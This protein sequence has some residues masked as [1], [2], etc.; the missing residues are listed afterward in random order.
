MKKK[1]MATL[2][3][4][5]CCC[6]AATKVCRTSL[7]D[8]KTPADTTTVEKHYKEVRRPTPNLGKGRNEVIG[9]VLHHTAEPQPVSRSVNKL[10]DP[11]SGV[12]SHVVIDTDGTRYVLAPP[13]AVCWHAGKS[14]LNGRDGCNNFTVGIEF[15]G[16]T[17]EE[18]LTDDQ[19]QSAIEYMLPI[20]RQYNIS[21]TNIVTHEQIRNAW[22]KAH[23]NA[24]CYGKVDITPTEYERVMMALRK[25][26]AQ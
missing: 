18:P 21:L 11:K 10:C 19:I 16:N 14:H 17:L 2:L 13:T 20:I 15:Q 7:S 9:I 23:P 5:A 4:V 3:G 6:I 12:S 22:K 26:M 25:A 24:H 8:T 1:I